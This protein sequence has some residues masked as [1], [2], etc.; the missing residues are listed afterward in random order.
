MSIYQEKPWLS[1]YDRDQPAEISLEFSDALSMFRYFGGR[2]TGRDE[3]PKTVSGKLLR[4][5][6]RDRGS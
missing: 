6:L 5:E 4:R 3:L 2:I 1:R